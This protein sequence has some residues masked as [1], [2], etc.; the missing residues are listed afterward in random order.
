MCAVALDSDVTI[1][2]ALSSRV[3]VEVW[4]GLAIRFPFITC[5]GLGIC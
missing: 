2:L 4:C 1:R 3:V 5:L